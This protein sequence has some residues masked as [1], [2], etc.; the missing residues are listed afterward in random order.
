MSNILPYKHTYLGS[1]ISSCLL[2][3]TS[4]YAST[5][6]AESEFISS[7]NGGMGLTIFFVLL[8][9][10]VG[11][12]VLWRRNKKTTT[13]NQYDYT[14]RI[15]SKSSSNN[16]DE[17][18]DAEKELEWF[19][20]ATRSGTKVEKKPLEK[21][22]KH[23]EVA[24]GVLRNFEKIEH[25]HGDDLHAHAKAYQ[26]KM[27]K[28]Q[29]S[30]L[31][32]NSFLQLTEPRAYDLLPLSG[33]PALLSAIE[34]AN[35]E[36]E[37]DEA[38]R[39]LSVRVLAAFKTRNSVD[40]LSQIALYDLSATVRS[41]A[42]NIL[43]DFDHESVFEAIVL[44]CAD[45]TREVRAAAARGLFKLNFDRADAW[46]RIIATRDEFRMS[47]AARAATESGIVVK[48]LDRLLHE[49]MKVAYEAF[50]LIGLLIRSGETEQIFDAIRD[51][52]DERIKFA[53]LHVLSVMK[54]ERS[55]RELNKLRIDETIPSE[56][57][58]RIKETVEN[59]EQVM[60]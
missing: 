8:V 1:V 34:Q 5:A 57:A 26:E 17:G 4:G 10:A 37:E 30:Q 28:L 45:P 53:L 50:A 44:A 13:Q 51:S 23:T 36:F 42:V 55:L 58:V 54:D 35:E 47:H 20:K 43:T 15:R 41:K 39:A 46:K 31:P 16:H 48:S 27:K 52:K 6:D 18:V 32:I 24:D 59:F 7:A 49:D 33:D 29:Y 19:R 56:I 2:L 9:A 14:R 60:A 12:F 22:S 38:V 21:R 11:G 25:G 3:T 40:S